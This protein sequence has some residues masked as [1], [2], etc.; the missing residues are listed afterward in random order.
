LSGANLPAAYKA[1]SAFVLPSLVESGNVT[2]MEAMSV[3]TPVLAADRPYAHDL[4]EDAA[5]FFDPRDPD[6]FA[7]AAIDVLA[8]EPLRKRLSRLGLE[9]VQRRQE[10]RP[11][12]ILL[13]HLCQLA[14][15]GVLLSSAVAVPE[16]SG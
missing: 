12:R 3:G 14:E 7:N 8:N 9:L 11:Y 13:D 4:C 16:G 1:A 5:L 6:A 2:M 10:N 15:K